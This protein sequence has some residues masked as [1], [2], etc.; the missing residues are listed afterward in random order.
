MSDFQGASVLVTGGSRGI[1]REI[2]LRFADEGAARVAIGYLRNDAAAKTA[3]DELRARGAEPVL[4]RGSVASEKV[5]AQ[6]A[7]LGPLNA[8]VHSA[9][10]GVIRPALETED[11][12]WDWT[13]AANARALLSLARAAAPS[14]PEG[15]A[16]VGLSSLGSFRVL[17]NYVLVGTSKAAMEAV[18]RYLGVELAARGIR[19]NA[20][21]AGV[22]ETE[23]LEFFPNKEE[24]LR[25]ARDRTPAGRM[26][27]PAD[28][29][30]AVLFLCG[31]R[32]KMVCGHTLIVDG[33]FS[34][35]A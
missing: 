29:A 3:A 26:V 32:S 33:G 28:V 1:G 2:A 13:L 7:D 34:L 22:V 21:S 15:A 9:A 11:K 17:E 20:V 35:P 14:M 24:M 19:V 27:E 31:P 16:I 5:A 10:T 4:V 6:V 23:A 30:D 12:H 8:L 25:A 18:V